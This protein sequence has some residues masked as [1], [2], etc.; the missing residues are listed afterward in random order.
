MEKLAQRRFDD[1][2]VLVIY[3]D[4][5]MF[6]SHHVVGAVGVDVEGDKYVLGVR[7]GASENAVWW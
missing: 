5:M 3:L 2:D 1:V 4:G 7:E 6:S